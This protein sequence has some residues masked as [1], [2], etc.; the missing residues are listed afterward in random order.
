MTAQKRIGGLLFVF[1]VFAL[2]YNIVIAP[3]RDNFIINEKT[4]TYLVYTV[5]FLFTYIH[6]SNFSKTLQVLLISYESVLILKLGDIA[7]GLSSLFIAFLITHIYG[8]YRRNKLAK[9]IAS[10][11][12]IYILFSV[13]ALEH[14]PQKWVI[15]FA[16]LMY[17]IIFSL[18][19]WTI[20]SEKL[21]YIE[22]VN[23]KLD[24]LAEDLR[25]LNKKLS[26]KD[27]TK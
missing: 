15:S 1:S 23:R 14:E 18:V 25:Q 24:G 16:W 12:L 17:L 4:I 8:F 7:F 10:I 21:E 20:F 27:K 5:L 2:M 22:K 11:I 6:E 19:V 13:I 26:D 9:Y 3:T